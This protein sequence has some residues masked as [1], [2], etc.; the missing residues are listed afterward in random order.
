MS[1]TYSDTKL[2]HT[3]VIS[4]YADMQL[5]VCSTAALQHT[6]SMFSALLLWFPAAA[7]MQYIL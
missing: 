1:S 4:H 7:I 6:G 3:K 5:C 2:S